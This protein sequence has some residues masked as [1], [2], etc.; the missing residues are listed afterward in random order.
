MSWISR[1]ANAFRPGRTAADLDDELQFHLDQRIDD[2]VRGGMPRRE[3]ELLARRQLGNRLA[4]ARVQLRGEV[5]RLARLP[6]ARL[7]LRPAHARQTSH[8]EPGRHRLAG[9]AIG[10]CTAA[11]TLID[12]LIF[13]PL[14][15]PAPHQLIDLAR[16][17]PAFFS[18]D[19]QP[20]RIGFLQL[21][22]I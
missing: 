20:Q 11:F 14:P 5:R 7:P 12:A 19:N 21:P 2:L 6:A 1:I 22:A 4:P 10:A 18:P 8:R 16:V 9:L 17:M 13:R 15:L 3:A